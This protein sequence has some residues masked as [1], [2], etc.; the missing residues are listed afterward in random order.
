VKQT[1][2]WTSSKVMIKECL[3]KR[4]E[5]PGC[6]SVIRTS[7]T[8]REREEAEN[9]GGQEARVK[10]EIAE[11][12]SVL[13]E[14]RTQSP[15]TKDLDDKYRHSSGKTVRSVISCKVSPKLFAWR[16]S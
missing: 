14:P 16:S 9:G 7:R 1:E 15:R 12:Q 11:G 6:L 10:Y 5:G 13:Q 3:E 2:T 8:R 4:K